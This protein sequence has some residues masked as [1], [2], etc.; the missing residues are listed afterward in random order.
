MWVSPIDKSVKLDL[1]DLFKKC[2]LTDPRA[3]AQSK[4]DGIDISFNDY[5]V[6]RECRVGNKP[7]PFEGWADDDCLRR[8]IDELRKSLER[9]ST[10]HDGWLE[11]FLS[12]P[13]KYTWNKLTV[14]KIA[15]RI[16]LF[17][18]SMMLNSM[19]LMRDD[20]DIDFTHG[21]YDPCAGF[22]GRQKGAEA[23]FKEYK[24]D[25][26]TYEGYDVNAVLE[27]QFGWTHRDALAERTKT[28]R[29]VI[30]S[31]PYNKLE[32][33]GDSSL[34]DLSQDDWIDA[35]TK[36]VKAPAYGFF[37]RET[38]HPYVTVSAKKPD[39]APGLFKADQKL[40]IIQ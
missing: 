35:I 20:F 19:K 37:V 13:I 29:V 34:A 30:T 7:S 6:Y 1:D 21:V 36:N 10:Y 18:P 8:A 9:E 17:R 38:K 26:A 4:A 25:K 23:F 39:A 2:K 15:P 32:S 27:Q 14:A 33:W 11:K 3:L 16:T 5:W 12:N 40:V 24:L 22:G 28:K 31:T